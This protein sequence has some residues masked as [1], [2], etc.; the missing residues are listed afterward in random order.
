MGE[1]GAYLHQL[2]EKWAKGEL[3]IFELL[4]EFE[5][6]YEINV[7]T[8]FPYLRNKKYMGDDYYYDA[9]D[10][11]TDFDGIGDYEILGIEDHFEIQIEDF[12]FNGYI[13]L[14]LKDKNDQLIVWDWKS[15][16]SFKD[17]E[18]EKHYR[19]QLYLYSYYVKE[20]YGKFPSST[21]STCSENSKK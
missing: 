10:F 11:F 9:I 15:K 21:Y 12:I 8:P 20:K 7:P 6:G 18:E 5:N 1:Y 19:R 2:L 3:E 17:A 4:T 14:I 13:D 16:K